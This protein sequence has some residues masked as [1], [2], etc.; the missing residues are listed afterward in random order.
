L[1]AA[2]LEGARGV[3]DSL[4]ITAPGTPAEKFGRFAHPVDRRPPRRRILARVNR[5]E[6]FGRD[7]RLVPELL[8]PGAAGKSIAGRRGAF[9]DVF[10]TLPAPF[11]GLKRQH[12]RPDAGCRRIASIDKMPPHDRGG[13]QRKSRDRQA[14]PSA[15][16]PGP[17]D[18]PGSLEPARHRARGP[19][20]PPRGFLVAQPFEVTEHDRRSILFRQ[21][22][23]LV[24]HDLLKLAPGGLGERIRPRITFVRHDARARGPASAER[25]CAVPAPAFANA[26]GTC[27]PCE[28]LGDGAEPAAHAVVPGDTRRRLAGQY[29]KGRLRNILRLVRVAKHAPACADD[30]RPVPADQRGE[31]GLIPDFRKALEKRGVAHVVGHASVDPP[32]RSPPSP[33]IM[34]RSRPAKC[35]HSASG[36]GFG[37][38]TIRIAGNP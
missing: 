27:V 17:K 19:A 31:R 10:E 2:R 30:A 23:E 37:P 12:R 34:P 5:A 25:G 15:R 14:E 35:T 8:E 1:D 18:A 21:P 22:T 9:E 3:P 24:A 29:E 36:P 33:I 4:G 38:R 26:I 7:G 28:S 13:D 32:L 6:R 20:E 16:E 11:D